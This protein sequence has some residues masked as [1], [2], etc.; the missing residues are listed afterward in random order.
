[1]IKLK[2]QH[3]RN[4]VIPFGHDRWFLIIYSDGISI[5]PYGRDLWFTSNVCEV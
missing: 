3:S 1:M 4:T 2:E 5:T